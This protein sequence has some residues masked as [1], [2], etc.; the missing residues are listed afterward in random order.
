[1]IDRCFSL[2]HPRYHDKNLKFIINTL[3]EN[4]HPPDFIFEMIYLRLKALFQN[5]MTNSKIQN[6]MTNSPPK[7]ER[8][9]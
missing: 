2:S 3:L 6:N 9:S 8:T 7:Q 1:M 5:N 4:N